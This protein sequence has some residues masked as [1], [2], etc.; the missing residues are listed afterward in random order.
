MG[1]D[2]APEPI[3]PTGADDS[4]LAATPKPA[5]AA[6]DAADTSKQR[7]AWRASTWLKLCSA[8]LVILA[9]VAYLMRN[10]VLGTP[11]AV[12]AATTGELVQTVVASGRVISPHRVSVALQGTGRVIRVAVVEGQTVQQGQLLIELDNSDSRASLAQASANVAQAQARLPQ[13]GELDQP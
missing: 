4:N 10:V 3:D 9:L 5:V 2:A 13:L 12:V 11:T 8:A 1:A 7:P 6:P